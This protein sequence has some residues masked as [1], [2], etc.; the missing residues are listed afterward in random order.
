MSRILFLSNHFITLHSFRKEL[1]TKLT[2]EGNEVYISTPED[3]QNVFFE[4]LGCKVIPTKMSRRGLN[5]IE[6]ISLIAQYKKIMKEVNPDVIFSYTIKPNIYG[7]FASNATGYKQVCNITGTGA[8]FLKDNILSKVCRMLYKASV[9]KCYKVFFQNTGD[10]DYFVEHKMVK[11]NWEMLP[12]SG[13]NLDE[14]PYCQLPDED[15]TRFIFIGRVMKLKGI[16]EYLK[17]A[18]EIKKKYDKTE[19]IIAGWNEEETYKE[20]VNKYHEQ[21]I[22]NYIGFRKDINDWVKKCTCVVLPSHG[23]EGVP[24]VLLEAAATGR[25]CIASKINGSK[26][27]VTDNVTGYLF[28]QGDAEDLIKK[29]DMFMNLSYE[30]RK[31]MGVAGRR[32]VEKEFDRQ[33]VVDAYMNEIK[34]ISAEGKKYEQTV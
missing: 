16:D 8:T 33:I 34:K 29:V 14:H 4:E 15:V 21:G 23:G 20:I 28:E 17:C 3:E 6:D 13:C 1:I 5:P 24:N 2:K 30:E 32:K 19:F 9:K 12:G 27:V 7:A 22:V 11:N 10:K 18:E 31:E 25:P 26:D